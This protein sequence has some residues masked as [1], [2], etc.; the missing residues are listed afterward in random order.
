MATTIKFIP[1][2]PKRHNYPLDIADRLEQEVEMALN[3]DIRRS[4]ELSFDRRVSGWDHKPAFRSKLNRRA[5][6]GNL[7]GFSLTV[8]PFGKNKRIWI[9]VSAGVPQHTILP[10]RRP[11]LRVRGGIGGYSAKTGTGDVYGGA[12]SYDDGA[13]FYAKRVHHPGIKARTFETF[14][15]S[16]NER[17]VIMEL[18]K[19]INRALL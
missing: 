11:L 6:K 17:F 9:F 7:T 3:G 18:T 14:I 15:A 12:G 16:E 8:G 5:R 2:L 10:K 19:A 13:T 4:L 1:I